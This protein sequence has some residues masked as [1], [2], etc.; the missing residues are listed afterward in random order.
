LQYVKIRGGGY[1]PKVRKSEVGQYVHV[2]RLQEVKGG[3]TP[4]S[5]P[6]IL[7]INTVEK[8]GVLICGGKCAGTFIVNVACNELILVT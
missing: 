5:K 8:Y 7:R 3:L 6:S 4:I 2:R 1:T